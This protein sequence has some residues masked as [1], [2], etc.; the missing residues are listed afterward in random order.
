MI[1][2]H[3]SGILDS[4][5]FQNSNQKLGF[6]SHHLPWAILVF[7][8]TTKADRLFISGPEFLEKLGLLVAVCILIVKLDE[9]RLA[10]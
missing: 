8:P 10:C 7:L 1:V 4:I 2:H 5:P 9:A 6:L 3:K